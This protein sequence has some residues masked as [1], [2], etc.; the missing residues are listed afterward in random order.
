[1]KNLK[2]NVE[3]FQIEGNYQSDPTAIFNKLCNKKK[4]TLLLE[5]AEIDKKHNL[6]SMIILD[7]AIRISGINN[8]VK[9]ESITDNG[10]SL[11]YK[12][13]EILPNSVI[14]TSLKN[15]RTLIFPS[16][17]YDVDED[18]K[19]HVLSIFDIFRLFLK[20]MNPPKNFLKSI[21]FGGL[22]AYDLIYSFEQLPKLKRTQKCPDFCFY[23][24]ETL[25]IL[26]HQKKTCIIQS[27]LFYNNKI[28]KQR[29]QQRLQNIKIELAKNVT[30]NYEINITQPMSLTSNLTDQ[31]YVYIIKKMQ[32]EVR[33]GNVFQVVPSRKFYIPCPCS[34]AAYQKLKKNNPSPYMFFMQDEEFTLF[35]ASPE[36]ALKY[37]A[38]N[39]KIEIYPIAGT[40]PRGK[41]TDGSFNFDLD[42]RIE[43][44][45]RTDKKELSEHLMLVDLA[46]NDLARICEPGSRY[47]ENLTKVD[48]YSCVM[49]LVSKVVGKLKYNLDIFHAYSACM[50]MGTLT[51]APKVK[52][53]QLIAQYESEQR[54]SYGGSIGYF[55]ETSNLDTCI[56]IRSA[57]VE[58]EIATVQAGAGIVLDSIPIKEVE[59]S[60]NKAKAV[61]QSIIEAHNINNQ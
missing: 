52:A 24:A 46:R 50:N 19:L 28:E 17:T 10:Q 60:R 57:Y 8:I 47:V 12:L 49:H 4:Y 22:F 14:S 40:R 61:I 1:M 3:L 23:L 54:G 38:S 32:N 7:S 16:M 18:N 34:L 48:R 41:N 9:I 42:N 6:E 58:N 37:N 53:M 15:S 39:R 35:G 30:E 13:D 51:G 29:L 55:T 26:D 25:L 11:L 27:S 43:L 56:I 36:S 20:F 5:S 21:F 2:C 59:E 33:K 45:M 31:E 44:E